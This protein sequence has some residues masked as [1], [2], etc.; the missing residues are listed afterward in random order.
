MS[1]KIKVLVSV[2]V[3]VLLLSVGGVATVMADDG[4]TATSNEVGSRSLF[5][6][7]ADILDIP[8]E[9][10]INAFRQARQEMRDVAFA[11][12]LDK[13]VEKQLITEREADEIEEWWEERPESLD[14]LPPG[15]FVSKGLLGRPIWGPCRGWSD[16][17]FNR[18]MERG[19]ITEDEADRI[20]QRCQ[21]RLET[22]NRLH[23]RDYIHQG[24]WRR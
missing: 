12:Y 19:L 13:A 16:E 15:C 5:A 10:L 17:A 8:E 14:C 22:Q 7:V 9:D 3:A 1:K 11:R 20:R 23:L 18:A 21:N 2:L 6:R 24:M 4:S